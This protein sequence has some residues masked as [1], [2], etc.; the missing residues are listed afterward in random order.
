MDLLVAEKI[1]LGISAITLAMVIHQNEWEF[2]LGQ[3][4]NLTKENS[5]MIARRMFHLTEGYR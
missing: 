1:T 4:F 5:R 2:L 3:E